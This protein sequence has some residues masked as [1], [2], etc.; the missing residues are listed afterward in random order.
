VRSIRR[1]GLADVTMGIVFL[2]AATLVMAQMWADPSGHTPAANISD[3]TAFEWNLSH[4]LRVFTHGENPLVTTQL[5][6]PIGVNLMANSSILA[7]ALPFAPLTAALGPSVVFVLLLTLGLAGTAFAWYYVL[8]RHF[9]GDRVAALVGGAICGFGPG[10]IAH[11]NGHPNITA[12]FLVPL[13]LWRA[14]ALRSSTHLW[15]D[16]AILAALVVGQVFINEEI[17]LYT[18]FAGIVFVLAYVAFRPSAVRHAARPMLTGLGIAVLIAGVALAYPLWYQF[19]GPG[20]VNGLPLS[21]QGEAYR[22]PLISY[23]TLPSL[24]WWGDPVHN[25]VLAFPTEENSFLGWP[26]VGV[27]L[28]I[29]VVLWRRVPAV[30]ALFVVG[31]VFTYA[32]LG[33]RVAITKPDHSY[34]LSLWSH[35]ERLPVFDNVLASRLGLVVLPV[36]GILFAFAVAPARRTLAAAATSPCH[37]SRAKI[38]KGTAAAARLAVMAAALVTI[39]PLQIPTTTRERVPTFFTSGTWS[40]YVPDG[41]SVLSATP[42]D[43]NA[44]MRWSIVTGLAFGI[45]GGYFFGPDHTGR[46]RYGPVPRPTMTLL[47]RASHGRVYAPITVAEFEQAIVDLRYWRTA[48]VVLTPD[49]PNAANMHATIDQLLGPGEQVGDVWLWNALPITS[50]PPT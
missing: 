27:A 49:Q 28:A 46:G 14:L 4:A 35:L 31:V 29:V 25:L 33:S 36:V 19:T 41:Y 39:V 43:R 18:A 47:V 10:I 16:G 48:I 20:H 23:S 21:Q 5:N 6:V 17:L 9:I 42:A 8:S 2:G 40:H 32:S 7:L 44:N 12:Q 22:L 26:V 38:I 13:I 15:R 1:G 11:A 3:Q 24:S 34:P 45:P 30:R 37:R 50:Q